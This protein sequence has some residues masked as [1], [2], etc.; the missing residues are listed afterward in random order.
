MSPAVVILLRV[1]GILRQVSP[2]GSYKDFAVLAACG[3]VVATF[4]RVPL[5]QTGSQSPQCLV[6]GHEKAV[7]QFSSARGALQQ[8]LVVRAPARVTAA[9][10]FIGSWHF[11]TIEVDFVEK[12]GQLFIVRLISHELHTCSLG[13]VGGNDRED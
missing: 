11:K 9:A 12:K 3:R 10:H 6:K 5:T 1:V 2:I 8:Q 13:L 7:C 4:H